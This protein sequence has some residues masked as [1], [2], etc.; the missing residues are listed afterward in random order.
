MLWSHG[1]PG[2]AC[3]GLT[4]ACGGLITAPQVVQE[5]L[6]QPESGWGALWESY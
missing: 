6:K 2:L 4:L 3:G 1:M 5:E